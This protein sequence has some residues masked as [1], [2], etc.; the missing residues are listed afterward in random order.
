[1]QRGLATVIVGGLIVATA[2]TL[3][4]LPMLYLGIEQAVERR[5]AR[6]ARTATAVTE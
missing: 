6:R 5:V 3:V 2:L 4:I 1:V